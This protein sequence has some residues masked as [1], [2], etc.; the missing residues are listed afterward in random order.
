MCCYDKMIHWGVPSCILLKCCSIDKLCIDKLCWGALRTTWQYFAV[1]LQL[2][3]AMCTKVHRWQAD[4]S[5]CTM[6]LY[7]VAIFFWK[8]NLCEELC[9]DDK[10]IQ[11]DP[12]YPPLSLIWNFQTARKIRNRQSFSLDILLPLNSNDIL[13]NSWFLSNVFIVLCLVL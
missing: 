7:C 8:C 13:L 12:Q 2:W 5:R 11:D 10:L 1:T 4:L 3:Q 9:T 6:C